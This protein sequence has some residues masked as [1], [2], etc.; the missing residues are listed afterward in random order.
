[1]VAESSLLTAR[2]SLC[3]PRS[4]RSL[5]RGGADLHAELS[6]LCIAALPLLPTKDAR[7]AGVCAGRPTYD[8]TLL[9]RRGLAATRS[10]KKVSLHEGES[11][12]SPARKTYPTRCKP[13]RACLAACLAEAARGTTP[14]PVQLFQPW[15]TKRIVSCG[16]KAGV[17][18]T[19]AA[20]CQTASICYQ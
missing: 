12:L 5:V 18:N 19:Y 16:L 17:P 2:L 15:V 6:R 10:S 14:C 20:H 11:G 1:M 9:P 8:P 4:C 13:G 3:K 7:I